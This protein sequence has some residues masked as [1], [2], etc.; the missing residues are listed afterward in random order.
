MLTGVGAKPSAPTAL[1]PPDEKSS[2][3]RPQQT[4]LEPL[5]IHKK[6]LKSIS[7]LDSGSF[8]ITLKSH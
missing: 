4:A 6:G 3:A 7:R 8:P 1:H 5:I 2:S